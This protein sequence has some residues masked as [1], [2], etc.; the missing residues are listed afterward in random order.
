MFNFSSEEQSRLSPYFTNMHSDIFG[1]KLPQEVAGALFSRYSRSNKS[2]RKIFLDEFLGKVDLDVQE[3]KNLEAV[4]KARE[5]Y[6]RVLIGYGDDSVAQL[7]G[8]HLACEN[9]SNVAAKTLEDSRIGIAPLEKSTRYVKF[10]TKD[11]NGEYL[12]YKEP[13]IMIS[14]YKQEYLDLMNKLFDTYSSLMSPMIEHLKTHIPIESISFR[15][16]K[17]GDMIGWN[18]TEGFPELRLIARKAYQS[19]LRS[20]ACDILR[21]FL[22]AAT[23]TNVGLFGVGQAFEHLLNKLFSTEL[24]EMHDIAL[25]SHSELKSLIPSFVKRVRRDEYLVQTESETKKLYNSLSAIANKNECRAIQLLLL[26]LM[27]MPKTK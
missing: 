5:F 25:S 23:L 1:L 9:V 2:L 21:S 3:D 18:N 12:F 7:G 27:R 4:E 10:D 26:I 11:E 24:A 16:P 20:N 19:S 8:A 13:S 22:P 6:D 14:K 15:E 17:T